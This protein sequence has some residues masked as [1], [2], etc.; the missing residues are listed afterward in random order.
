[1]IDIHGYEDKDGHIMK[2]KEY[3]DSR[4]INDYIKSG[5]VICPYCGSEDIEGGFININIGEAFQEITCHSCDKRWTDIYK[6]IW[7]EEEL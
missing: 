6:L 7:I 5:G 1:M 2:K 4:A 3:I